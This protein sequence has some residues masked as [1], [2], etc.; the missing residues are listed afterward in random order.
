MNKKPATKNEE[1][2]VTQKKKK[3]SPE[4]PKQDMEGNELQG[5]RTS[6]MSSRLHR[7]TQRFAISQSIVVRMKV[8]SVRIGAR[9]REIPR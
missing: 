1:E 8:V 5:T 3:K 9:D 2:A 4:L 7:K 6:L